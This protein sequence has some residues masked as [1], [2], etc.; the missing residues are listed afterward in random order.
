MR[1]HRLEL[2]VVMAALLL[3]ACSTISYYAQSIG[4]QMGLMSR[5]EPVQALLTDPKID[6]DL[7]QHLARAQEIRDFASQVLA[8]P[9]NDSYRSYVQ[10]N[11]PFV[12]WSLFATPEFSLE[13][14]QWCFPIAGCVPYRGYFAEQAAR[15]FAQDL[16][17]Q[18]MDVFVGGV[19]AYSTLGWFDDPLLS[20]MLGQGEAGTAAII[21]HE[22]AHQQ[23]YVPGDAAFNE[24]F[25]VAVEKTGVY[26]WLARRG[27]QEELRDYQ[28][29]WQRK[30]DFFDLV[31]GTR[32]RLSALYQSDVNAALMREAKR[33]IIAAMRDEYQELKRRWGGFAGYDY[34]FE[35]PI[36]NA[37]LMAVAVY[38]DLVAD[39]ER[40]FAACGGDFE[41]FYREVAQLGELESAERRVR[42]NSV[43]ACS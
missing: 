19:P 31:E 5:R 26:R 25:A 17:R 34:W 40:W 24:G 14:R 10:L 37:K 27:T 9:D 30:Q 4:G 6:T 2:A 21:F 18:G 22:L 3:P 23:V 8:L 15:A 28:A 41:R 39:F 1:I 42:L 12:V 16:R 36:N 32:A 43:Q 38:R 13:P 20:S 29:A 33:K 11:H 7:K 35:E